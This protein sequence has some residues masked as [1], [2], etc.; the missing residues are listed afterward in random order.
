MLGTVF[1]RLC[2]HEGWGL[3]THFG[4]NV[5]DIEHRDCSL[6]SVSATLVVQLRECTYIE[7]RSLQVD[8]LS[9]ALGSSKSNISSIQITYE[10]E[11]HHD[12]RDEAI[13]LPEKFCLSLSV[14][15]RFWTVISDIFLKALLY[16]LI[17]Y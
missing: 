15:D 8:I 4:E 2:L 3:Q 6:N 10:H 1:V 11:K 16:L 7:F 12:R 17:A 14:V 5:E 13:K 9:H